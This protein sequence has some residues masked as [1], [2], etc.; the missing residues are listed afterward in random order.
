MEQAPDY[1]LDVMGVSR[2]QW[3]T[4]SEEQ[5]LTVAKTTAETISEELK[6]LHDFMIEEIVIPLMEVAHQIAESLVDVAATVETEIE[7]GRADM[8]AATTAEQAQIHGFL[9]T[10]RKY[11]KSR[12][13]N[14]MN[15]HR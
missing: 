14:K 5:Q 2:E 7:A 1:V 9:N 15:N 10:A 4:M 6:E 8:S 3:H 11:D 13:L 12:G